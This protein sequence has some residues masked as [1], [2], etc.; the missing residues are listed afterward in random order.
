M[1]SFWRLRREVGTAGF[2]RA[3]R[4]SNAAKSGSSEYLNHDRFVSAFA[5]G[6][7]LALSRCEALFDKQLLEVVRACK[8]YFKPIDQGVE[9]VRRI[10]P[11]C[12]V[13]LA[14]N[15]VL[16]QACT[17]LRVSWTGLQVSDFMFITHSQNSRACKPSSIYYEAILSLLS[18]EGISRDECLF[19]GNDPEDD[20]PAARVGITTILLNSETCEFKTLRKED[21]HGA[22]LYEASWSVIARQFGAMR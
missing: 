17:Y 9:F 12:R 10:L 14:T 16:P 13:V 20:G 15:P 5:E 2:F 22:A 4:E 7:G 6:T 21:E 11:N 1:K 18:K 19:I 3:M 8:R